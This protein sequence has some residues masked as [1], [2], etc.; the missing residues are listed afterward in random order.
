MQGNCLDD[1]EQWSQ[2][3]VQSIVWSAAGMTCYGEFQASVDTD[4][5]CEKL[6]VI[7]E[8]MVTAFNEVGGD[9]ND[10]ITVTLNRA[11]RVRVIS[12]HVGIP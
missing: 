7:E 4:I 2:H 6:A 3:A 12:H 10:V 11:Y 1:S 8:N 5:G 9:S